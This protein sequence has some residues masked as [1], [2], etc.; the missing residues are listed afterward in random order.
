MMNVIATEKPQDKPVKG[1][2]MP[3]ATEEL[4]NTVLEM[5]KRVHLKI[6]LSA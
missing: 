2:G 1:T 6:L 5:F 3:E 4:R